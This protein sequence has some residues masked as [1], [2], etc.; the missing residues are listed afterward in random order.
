MQKVF[1][2]VDE[3]EAI[4][5]SMFDT[6]GGNAKEE[7]ITTAMETLVEDDEDHGVDAIGFQEACQPWYLGA[8]STN[9]LQQC[10]Y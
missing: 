6:F 4:F 8:C 5:T 1:V 9:L 3:F 2:I 7:P 10:Y